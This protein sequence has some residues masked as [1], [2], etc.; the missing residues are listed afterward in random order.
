VFLPHHL[1]QRARPQA[2]RKRRIL[3]QLAGGGGRD[4]FGKQVGHGAYV[5]KGAGNC[6]ASSRAIVCGT[7]KE[8]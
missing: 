2:V 7:E 1:G 6:I 5:A 8:E 3:A 4:I